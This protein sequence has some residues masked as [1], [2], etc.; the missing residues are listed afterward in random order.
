MPYYH[1]AVEASKIDHS[2]DGWEVSL[3]ET[4][5]VDSELLIKADKFISKTDAVSMIV[6]RDNSIVFEKYYRGQLP[7]APCFAFP[8]A[9]SILSALTGIAIKNGSIQSIDQKIT[10]LLPYKDIPDPDQKLSKIT[11]KHLLTM[12]TGFGEPEEGIFR[13]HD[14]IGNLLKQPIINDPGSTFFYSPKTNYLLSTILTKTT[15]MNAGEMSNKLLLGPIRAS[16]G[17]WHTGPEN[18]NIGGEYLYLNTADMAKFG[19]L[20][21]N[22]GKWKNQQVIPSDWVRESLE[23]HVIPS[24]NQRLNLGDSCIGFGYGFVIRSIDNHI[25]YT[26]EGDGSMQSICIIPELDMVVAISTYHS[27]FKSVFNYS[28]LKTL[29]QDYII[30]AVREE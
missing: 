23:V 6:V 20:Y 25:V 27:I 26:T 13:T 4:K 14:W 28:S 19:S 16:I 24:E 2:N 30:P 15:G 21:L 7:S 22:E 8:T 5:G 18:M 29:L 11:V 17:V 3:P 1:K 12:T 10:E 9:N